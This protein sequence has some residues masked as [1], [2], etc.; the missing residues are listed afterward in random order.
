MPDQ[1]WTPAIGLTRALRHL[2]IRSVVALA[3]WTALLWLAVPVL[4][5]LVAHWAG[6]TGITRALSWSGRARGP[7]L[8]I[9]QATGSVSLETLAA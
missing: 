2:V 7:P 5:L 4:N 3:V 1:E 8:I 9:C 6:A